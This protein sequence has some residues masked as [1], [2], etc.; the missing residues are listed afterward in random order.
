MK[1]NS[2]KEVWKNRTMISVCVYVCEELPLEKY[3]IIE[4][5][6]SLIIKQKNNEWKNNNT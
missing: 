1:R 5:L 3:L 6:F 4:I 2:K